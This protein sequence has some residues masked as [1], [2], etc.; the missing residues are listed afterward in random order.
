MFKHFRTYALH[1]SLTCIVWRLRHIACRTG[2]SCDVQRSYS[3]YPAPF[4]LF[5]CKIHL[6]IFSV[7]LLM[8]SV[9]NTTVTTE[10]RLW[11]CLQCGNILLAYQQCGNILLAYQQTNLT[12]QAIRVL[13]NPL[14]P[15]LFFLISAHPVYKMWITQEPKKLALW[16]KLHFEEKKTESVKHV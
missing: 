2:R 15:E 4:V 8:N 5:A 1:D 13:I 16:N 10:M 6:F 7:R 12:R 9:A 11:I 14:A 3:V